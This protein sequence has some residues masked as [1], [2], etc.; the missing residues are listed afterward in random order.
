MPFSMLS[1]LGL[2][3]LNPPIDRDYTEQCLDRLATIIPFEK[4]NTIYSS[5]SL[6]C[7]DTAEVIGVYIEKVLGKTVER[8]TI[9]ELEEVYFDLEKLNTVIDIQFAMKQKGVAVAVNSGVFQ[10]MMSGT[11]C[12]PI[13]K[14]CE[15]VG[16]FFKMI[17]DLPEGKNIFLTHDFLMRVMEIYIRNKGD[18]THVITYEEL[19]A[20]KRNLYLQGFA[21][22]FSLSTFFDF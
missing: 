16:K 19:L 12:E 15:R 18:M 17:Q 3:K 14:V 2:Q 11:Y 6:R 7:Q 1:D 13:S 20:T 22:N 4:I 9:P 10:G 8:I 21:T 5:P